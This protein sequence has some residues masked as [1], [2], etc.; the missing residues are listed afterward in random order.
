MCNIARSK[1]FH[2]LGRHVFVNMWGQQ[3]YLKNLIVIE[4]RE[5]GTTKWHVSNCR[6]FA[7]VQRLYARSYKQRKSLLS[8][9]WLSVHL[10]TYITA[11]CIGRILVKFDSGGIMVICRLPPIFVEIGQI[12]RLLPQGL[13]C[14]ILAARTRCPI[15]CFTLSNVAFI[16]LFTNLKDVCLLPAYVCVGRHKSTNP[17]RLSMYVYAHTHARQYF[18]VIALKC[19]FTELWDLP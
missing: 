14:H 17:S 12:F 2:E 19:K 16:S 8:S 10:S 1:K 11:D 4:A 6:N 3:G 5:I 9:S 15:L 18:S 7:C 13:L